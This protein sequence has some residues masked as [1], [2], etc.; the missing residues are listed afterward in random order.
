MALSPFLELRDI[1]FAGVT[2]ECWHPFRQT[3]GWLFVATTHEKR[4][5]TATLLTIGL[6]ESNEGASQGV[7]GF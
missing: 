6:D 2:Q 7:A 3:P 1:I 4:V 5:G